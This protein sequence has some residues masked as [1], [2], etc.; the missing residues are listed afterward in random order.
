MKAASIC[1]AILFVVLTLISLYEVYEIPKEFAIPN[2]PISMVKGMQKAY[3]VWTIINFT[4]S[5]PFLYVAIKRRQ[6]A[7]FKILGTIFL[8]Y[9]AT[10]LTI[11]FIGV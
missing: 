11:S 7:K 9:I 10:I 1:L 2:F 5:L 8:L 6:L 3:I 4:F